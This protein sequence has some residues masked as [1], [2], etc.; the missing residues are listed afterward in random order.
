MFK[1][2]HTL[3]GGSKRDELSE[4]IDKLTALVE[5]LSE[6][7]TNIEQKLASAEEQVGELKKV[8]RPDFKDS[9]EP[10]VEI[11]SDRIDPVKGLVIE[12]DW[13]DAFVQYLKDSGFEGRDEETIVHK[14]LSVLYQDMISRLEN[15]SIENT[16]RRTTV[17]DY[18]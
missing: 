1:W 3:F 5:T 15:Q 11:I 14:W 12:L 4:R 16:S 7:K 8:S 6:E 17:K 2:I 10:H 18:L 13:N 9:V